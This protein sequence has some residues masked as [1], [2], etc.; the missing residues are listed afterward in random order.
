METRINNGSTWLFQSPTVVATSCLFW[1]RWTHVL[2]N[3]NFYL[4]FRK[5]TKRSH[6]SVV[7]L[8]F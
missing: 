3:D 1:S 6:Y 5:T 4:R 8:L 7:G 2:I